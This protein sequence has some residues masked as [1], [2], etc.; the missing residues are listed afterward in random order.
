[1]RHR[2]RQAAATRV[3][4]TALDALLGSVRFEVEGDEHYRPY[5]RAGRAVIF[6]L[7]HGRLLPLSF[8]HRGEGLVTLISRS[9]DGEIIAQVV[10]QW[11]Y[12]AVRGSTSSRGTAALRE[13]VRHARAGRSIAITPDGPR[14]PRNTMK[15]GALRVAQL[16]GAPVVAAAAGTERAWWFEQWDRFIVPKP[17]A[18]VRLAYSPPMFV[19]RDTDEAGL[20]ELCRQAEDALNALVRKVDGEALCS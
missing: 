9:R 8:R 15:P 12:T 1:M 3:A 13:L 14:G 2:F 17:F 4:R 11:G 6:V 10:E 7:W 5:Q 18:R 16:T 19:P 20:A